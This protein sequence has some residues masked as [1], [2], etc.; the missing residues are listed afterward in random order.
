MAHT[1]DLNKNITSETSKTR[2][3][4]VFL[5]EKGHDGKRYIATWVYSVLLL[6][7][8]FVSIL[9]I[10]ALSKGEKPLNHKEIRL[11][12]EGTSTVSVGV[13]QGDIK[14]IE[15]L[16]P[17]RQPQSQLLQE[18][19]TQNTKTQ[20][21]TNNYSNPSNLSGRN[22]KEKGE[23]STKESTPLTTH[24]YPVSISITPT[25]NSQT[26]NQD[27]TDNKLNGCQTVSKPDKIYPRLN[28][29]CPR[30]NEPL[31]PKSDQ[32]IENNQSCPT[33]GIR[34]D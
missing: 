23:Y 15:V 34:Q 5:T 30:S 6:V 12:L 21:I 24:T 18:A 33:W 1:D 2:F 28:K 26:S 25:L 14:Y 9:A 3:T 22:Q 7:S 27:L 31:K 32:W 4:D 19:Q 16:Q 29:H 13:D 11:Q 10:P 20:D 17:Q 8:L